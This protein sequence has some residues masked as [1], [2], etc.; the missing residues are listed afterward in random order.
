[1]FFEKK[2]YEYGNEHYTDSQLIT[3]RL[4]KSILESEPLNHD[5]YKELHKT[6]IKSK[7]IYWDTKVKNLIEHLKKVKTSFFSPF[8]LIRSNF[9]NLLFRSQIPLLGRNFEYD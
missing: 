7:Q 1:M 2:F 4:S 5:N 9:R 6:I 3:Y 8:S